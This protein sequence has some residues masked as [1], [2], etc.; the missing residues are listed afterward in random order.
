M[1]VRSN[2]HRPGF[3]S[4]FGATLGVVG[5]W[6]AASVVSTGCAAALPGNGQAVEKPRTAA[7]FNRVEVRA[8]LDVAVK[9]GGAF[10]VNVEVDSNLQDHITTEVRGGT[11]VID[12]DASIAPTAGKNRVTVTLPTLAALTLAGSGN[13]TVEGGAE[14]PSVA[15]VLKGSGNMTYHGTAGLLRATV[16]STGHGNIKL[17]GSAGRIEAS[18]D[19]TGDI[20]ATDMKAAGGSFST[21][22]SG[23]ILANL[24]GGE[25]II[26]IHGSGDVRWKG[27][28][29]VVS[30]NNSGTGHAIKL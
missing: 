30:M 12:S 18:T 1:V 4:G 25:T 6:V 23:D 26:E 28:T 2:G 14:H 22:G 15:L 9:E 5:V 10:A 17:V 24:H 21:N 19:G 7:E 16:S 3:R 27:E 11:L 13:A 29:Q 20:D 8:P